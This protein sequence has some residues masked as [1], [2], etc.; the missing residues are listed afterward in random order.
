M[1]ATNIERIQEILERAHKE[2]ITVPL[3]DQAAFVQ[4][5][6]GS[7]L[8]A[9]CLGLKDTRTLTSWATGG[10]IRSEDARHRIQV[11]FRVT[12]AIDQTFGPSVAAA[13]LRGSNPVLGG[14]SPMTLLAD[15]A[16]RD[17][18]PRII[19]AVEALLTA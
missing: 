4:R 12:T 1:P 13:F 11:L 2:S 9:A 14:H 15:S 8:A 7:R 17:S 19:E 3:A 6:L 10:P 18:E 5:L 16:P